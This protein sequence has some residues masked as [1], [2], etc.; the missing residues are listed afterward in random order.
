MKKKNDAEMLS[1]GLFQ[2][3][4]P[5]AQTQLPFLYCPEPAA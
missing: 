4:P 2:G 1:I 3:F 5:K